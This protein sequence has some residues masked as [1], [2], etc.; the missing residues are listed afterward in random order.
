M[1]IKDDLVSNNKSFIYIFI[2]F[3][4]AQSQVMANLYLPSLPSI[5]VAL[6]TSVQTVQFSMAIFMLG[7][8]VTQLFYGPLSDAYGRRRL[9][10]T[11]L[12]MIIAGTLL[13]IVSQSGEILL[14]GRLLQGFGCGAGAAITRAIA[15]DVY[16]DNELSKFMSYI[17]LGAIPLVTMAPFIGG[18]VEATL[19]WRYNFVLLM[20]YSLILLV[21]LLFYKETNQYIDKS[22]ISTHYLRKN[23][24][25]LFQDKGFLRYIV[26]NIISFGAV[27]AWL[28]DGPFIVQTEL[29]FGPVV[30]GTISLWLGVCFAI[31]VVINS[32]V[33]YVLGADRM[34]NI[35]LKLMGLSAILLIV[36][37][38]RF[39]SL[40][41]FLCVLTLFVGGVSLVFPNSNAE[42]LRPF[43]TTAGLVGSFMGASQVMSGAIFS[44]V[45]ACITEKS[46]L[47]LGLVVLAA[48]LLGQFAFSFWKRSTDS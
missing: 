12:P 28:T 3:L 44:A 30:F 24:G 5:Q 36:A 22:H 37:H 1:P 18:V 2:V 4:A 16:R 21:M 27:L 41:L 9:I 14:L 34:I 32:R 35:G 48:T 8:S 47:A 38:N 33:V 25:A 11:G 43:K 10:A 13:V 42:C 40:S 46:V 39:V 17:A 6:R 45:M 23:I 20:A 26:V 29:G 15:R 31:G 7:L 19:G